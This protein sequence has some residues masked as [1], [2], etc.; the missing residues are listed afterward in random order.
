M[1]LSVGLYERLFGHRLART[2]AA[3]IFW[4]LARWERLVTRNCY[5]ELSSLLRAWR[6]LA[7]VPPGTVPSYIT[8]PARDRTAALARAEFRSAF[9]DAFRQENIARAWC[10]TFARFELDHRI[11]MRYPRNDDNPQRQ[12]DLMILKPPLPDGEKGV[13]MVMYSPSI[14]K[15]IAL[16]DHEHLAK[17]YRFVLE[18]STWGYQDPDLLLYL[19]L[20]TDV[21]VQS[22]YRPDFEHIQ[23]LGHNLIPL[24]VG[25]GDWVD[26]ARFSVTGQP[27]KNY[28]AVMVASWLK[29]KRHALLF[30]TM[31]ELGDRISRVALVGV[32]SGGRVRAD[33]AAEAR[34][35]GVLDKIV[36]FE[37][38]SHQE[39]ADVLQ[40]SRVSLMLSTREGASRTIYES[41]FCDVPVILTDRNIGVNRDHINGRTGIVAGDDDLAGAITDVL[42]GPERFSPRV[43]ALAHTGYSNATRMLQ[44]GLQQAAARA[45]EPWT[46][47]ILPKINAPNLHYVTT[48]DWQLAQAWYADLP[49]YLRKA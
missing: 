1:R 34:A 8:E 17:R 42:A 9:I 47:N 7:S 4:I 13:I 16:Y 35:A 5:R 10:T 39:V 43:W 24:R 30:T 11:R 19:H 41:L 49:P 31:R 28:D 25:A 22:Q 26:P 37:G 33:V 45:G 6:S 38:I 29:L 20:D 14:A 36:W 3:G 48:A 21:F 12:G 15:L 2:L 46:M 18:P 40:Q 23:T 44:E 32:P 27:S